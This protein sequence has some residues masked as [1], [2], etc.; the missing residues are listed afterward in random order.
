M[1]FRTH[2]AEAVELRVPRLALVPRDQVHASVSVSADSHHQQQERRRLPVRTNPRD[3]QQTTSLKRHQELLS[4]EQRT[5]AS[6]E[7]KQRD[8]GSTNARD[9]D[10]GLDLELEGEGELQQLRLGERFLRMMAAMARLSRWSLDAPSADREGQQEGERLAAPSPTQTQEKL[11]VKKEAAVLKKGRTSPL[12]SAAGSVSPGRGA[13]APL[14]VPTNA[15]TEPLRPHLTFEISMLL[16]PPLDTRQSALQSPIQRTQLRKRRRRR[17]RHRREKRSW[18]T[19]HVTWGP[20]VSAAYIDAHQSHDEDDSSKLVAKFAQLKSASSSA[21]LAKARSLP[22]LNTRKVLYAVRQPTHVAANGHDMSA[23]S[24]SS[25]GEC[26]SSDSDRADVAGRREADA[27]EGD[28]SS[29]D[30][31]ASDRGDNDADNDNEDATG[32][33]ER[34]F[35]SLLTDSEAASHTY[36]HEAPPRSTPH[37]Q[38]AADTALAP[39]SSA[40]QRPLFHP[41]ALISPELHAWLVASGLFQTRRRLVPHPHHPHQQQ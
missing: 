19:S 24:H 1:P 9:G 20:H 33:S 10:G 21:T 28:E 41:P 3:R 8:E 39:S 17:R 18:M 7:P 23:C 13:V 25:D 4:S 14:F 26:A 34:P 6:N 2:A 38:A 22:L 11:T 27:E 16:P 36:P 5:Q 15:A 37:A 12:K 31:T 40:L 29:S 30:A 32:D 35:R